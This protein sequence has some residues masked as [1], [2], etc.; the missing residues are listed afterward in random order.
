MKNRKNLIRDI[1]NQ[2]LILAGLGAALLW[3][4]KERAALQNLGRLSFLRWLLPCAFI[5]YLLSFI[6]TVRGLSSD[7][8]FQRYDPTDPKSLKLLGAEKRYRSFSPAR[9]QA[10]GDV[11]LE[12]LV[13]TL[14]KQGFRQVSRQ[15]FGLVL[16][17]GQGRQMERFMAI[18]KP[19]LNVIISER[20]IKEAGEYILNN[21]RPC[22]YNTLVLISNMEADSEV[23]SAAV[24]VVNFSSKLSQNT[25]FVPYVLDLVH[26]RLFYPQDMSGQKLSARRYGEQQRELMLKVTLQAAEKNAA[27]HLPRQRA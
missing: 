7:Y 1:I 13:H 9:Y 15:N 23:L 16:E 17:R 6:G 14:Q 3:L 18:Y 25:L 5:L 27:S 21:Q 11:V 12:H 20:H 26:G 4:F 24:A 22:R 19:M 10:Q 8:L 2:V